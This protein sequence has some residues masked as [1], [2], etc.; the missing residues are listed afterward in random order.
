[1]GTTMTAEQM[2]QHFSRSFFEHAVLEPNIEA[3]RSAIPRNRLAVLACMQKTGSTFLHY[4]LG[5]CLDRPINMACWRSD[6]AHKRGMFLPFALRDALLRETVTRAHMP[7]TDSNLDIL[8]AV[9]ATP[10]V[11][12]RSLFDIVVSA[13]DAIV[14]QLQARAWDGKSNRASRPFFVS[15]DPNDQYDPPTWLRSSAST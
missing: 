5:G 13:R 2:L 1:M 9:N 11:L 7:A 14:G 6:D 3:I 10:I 12:V 15:D 8:R 4:A